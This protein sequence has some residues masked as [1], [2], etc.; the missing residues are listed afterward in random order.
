MVLSWPRILKLTFHYA[1]NLQD[2]TVQIHVWPDFGNWVL[3]SQ[4]HLAIPDLLI[5][6]NTGDLQ[7]LLTFD[8]WLETHIKMEASKWKSSKADNVQLK[9]KSIHLGINAVKKNI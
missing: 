3:R 7:L 2:P 6:F 1:I 9:L 5:N 8:L 4:L